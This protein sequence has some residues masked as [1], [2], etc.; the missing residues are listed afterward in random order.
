[1]TE[2][3][4]A[5]GQ[6]YVRKGQFG[7]NVDVG[8]ARGGG[9]KDLQAEKGLATLAVGRLDGHPTP[10]QASNLMSIIDRAKNICL[11]PKTEWP[12]IAAETASTGS[13]ITGYVVPL[14][15]I[16]ALSGFVGGSVIGRNVPFVGMY[17]TSVVSGLGF[18][19]FTFVMAIV[20]VFVLSL[21]INALAPKFGGQQDSTLALKVAVYSYTPAWLAAVLNIL[22]WLGILALLGGLYSLY[23]LYLGL[24]RLMKCPEDK[25]A[26]YTGAIVL[27][28]ILLSIVIAAVGGRFFGNGMMGSGG[29]GAAAT[30]S[31]GSG[32]VQFDKNSAM[33]KL[34]DFG[35][36]MEEANKKTEAAAKSGDPNALAAAALEGLG[37]VFS[38][39]KHV[40]PI[41]LDQLKPFVPETFAGLTQKS[42]NAEKTGIESLMVSNVEATY[43][44]GAEKRV[45]LKI[46]DTGGASTLVGLA[47]WAN[48]KDEK[49]DDS[50]SERT[51][52]MDGRLVHEKSS[53]RPGG[54]NEFSVVLGERFVV[55]ASGVG[56]ELQQ[57]KAAV[58]SLSLAKLESMKDVGV[59]K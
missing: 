5:K 59:T 43:G 9:A 41:A 4:A 49:E 54:T 1:M 26:G 46:S 10:I 55:S 53:K 20:G 6:L 22:P 58:M 35:K 47:S 25:A 39:G 45:T 52:K 30:R 3:F 14:A 50:G 23:L 17:R 32:E 36:K 42:S 18:A 13:L 19:V 12:V 29:Y 28:A 37:T 40:D 38:G 34:Q 48:L 31:Q 16:G 8:Q 15:A 56:V 24:P 57:L 7:V 51:L 2:A 11:T 27:C 21:I 44:D 33:G